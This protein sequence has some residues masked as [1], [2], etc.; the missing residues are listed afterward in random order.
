MDTK[1][2]HTSGH[3][4]SEPQIKRFILLGSTFPLSLIRR[5]V[6]IEPQAIES[7]KELLRTCAVASFW[8]HQSTLGL[9]Q[10]ILGAD[11]MP[12]TER[13]ALRLTQDNLPELDGQVFSECW[14]LSPEYVPGFRPA[15]GEEVPAE[16]I[17]SW[18]VLRVKWEE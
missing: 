7:L 3:S 13:P 2:T 5:K 10:S 15:I 8:G 12:R 9:A 18:Q 11:L 4:H 6:V 16:K 1:M 14:V 17:R